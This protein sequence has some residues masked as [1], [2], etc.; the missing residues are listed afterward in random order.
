[1]RVSL[2]V[3]DCVFVFPQPSLLVRL[4]ATIRELE[5]SIQDYQLR[6]EQMREDLMEVC[7]CFSV[8]GGGGVVDCTPA[9]SRVVPAPFLGAGRLMR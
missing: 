7:G 8:V 6:C 4:T 5:S 9:L 2:C 3:R 1:M